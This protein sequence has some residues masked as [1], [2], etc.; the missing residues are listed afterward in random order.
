MPN[1]SSGT[2]KDRS[3]TTLQVI[4]N[5]SSFNNKTGALTV[6]GG[7]GILE[8]IN[9]GGNAVIDGT[10]QIPGT[11]ETGSIIIGTSAIENYVLT[12]LNS[13]GNTQ[14]KPNWISN[15]TN[16]LH[17]LNN[18][19]I[20]TTQSHD[21]FTLYGN[22][23]LDGTLNVPDFFNVNGNISFTNYL[24]DASATYVLPGI[25]DTIVGTGATQTLSNKTLVSP[26][27]SGNM[28]FNA[29]G[30]IINL[31]YPS[32]SSDAATKGYVDDLINGLDWQDSVL[33]FSIST[34]PGSP[35][36]GDRYIVPSLPSGAW[37][38]QENKITFWNGTIWEF[39]V[40]N[41]GFAVLI[42]DED[43]QY[44]YNGTSWVLFGSLVNH[45]SLIGLSNDEHIQY[46]LLAGRAGGQELYGGISGGDNLIIDS[47]TSTNKGDILLQPKGG[48]VGIGVTDSLY[49]LHILEENSTLQQLVVEQNN[50]SGQAGLRIHHKNDIGTGYNI[51]QIQNGQV[52]IIQTSASGH[53]YYY[54][55]GASSDYRFFN[56][57]SDLERFG[58]LSDGTVSIHNN[59]QFVNN[60]TILFNELV[61]N[62]NDQDLIYIGPTGNFGIGVSAQNQF[63][64]SQSA[65]IGDTL[66]IGTTGFGLTSDINH[67]T[68][69]S[70]NRV[71]FTTN[72]EQRMIIGSTGYIGIGVTQPQ[73]ILDVGG[74]IR[75]NG[76]IN[77]NTEI[78]T[79]PQT[80]NILVG[81]SS[82][83]TLTNKSLHDTSVYFVNQNDNTKVLDFSLSSATSGRT[84][85]IVSNH[86][87]NR[88]IF[89][90]DASDILVGKNTVDVLTNKTLTSPVIASIVN[91]GTLTLPISTDTLVGRNTVDTLTNKT[92][93]SPVI[94]GN[95]TMADTTYMS[96]DQVRARDVDGLLLTDDGNNG[97]FIQDGGNV[98]IG[99]STPTSTLDVF[100]DA[101]F[102]NNTLFVQQSTNSVGIGTNTPSTQ[103]H[104]NGSGYFENNLTVNGNLNVQG[105]LT[106]INT[107]NLNINDPLLK[108]ADGNSG[109]T[110]DIGFFG[111]F[112][113]GGVTKYTGLFRDT[114]AVN[115]T[116]R[117]FT[118]LETEPLNTIN[119]LG[120][121]YDNANLS[122]GDLEAEFITIGTLDTTYPLLINKTVTNNWSQR[123]NNNETTIYIGHS[124]G[125]GMSIHTGTVANNTYI[126][127]F[128]NNTTN[129]IFRVQ[130]NGLVGIQSTSPTEK[131][132]I[133]GINP[134]DGAKIGNAKIGVWEGNASY[135]AYTHDTVHG[136]TSSYAIKQLNT[137]ETYLNTAATKS[138]H[139]HVGD[140][141]QMIID[142]SGNVGI[143]TLSPQKKLHV[144][145]G[146]LVTSDLDVYG[147]LNIL[148]QISA[149][150]AESIVVQ[151]P[152]LKIANGNTMD[153]IDTGFYIQYGI[154]G[155]I[156]QG[157][158]Y[159][160]IIRDNDDQLFK[161]FHQ[162][163]IEPGTTQV[164]TD[165]ASFQYA[166]LHLGGA[167]IHDN[168]IIGAT[169][170]VGIGSN[171][172][173]SSLDVIGNGQFTGNV[174]ANQFI[175]LSDMTSKTNIRSLSPQQCIETIRK[176]NL[177][178][179]DYKDTNT[180]S[181]GV[182]AQQIEEMF[183]LA[184]TNQNGTKYVNYQMLF[185]LMMGCIKSLLPN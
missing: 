146:T 145:G 151:D 89:L 90:P 63:E 50:I 86:S 15:N 134:G 128:G 46:A 58:I 52:N 179:F 167:K 135:T 23:F 69:F 103:L 94:T 106:T 76:T 107:T 74:N 157:I 174:T 185:I 55:K 162:L 35:S 73:D 41:E 183:P 42:E 177:F 184:V 71:E 93:S 62:S 48:H 82:I 59:L 83:D 66:Y 39:I 57:N 27:V 32:L 56:T 138:L 160:G 163:A 136:I 129:D 182:M 9:V 75:I 98:G 132:D 44:N 123:I 54:N 144:E 1:A 68:L 153:L 102:N 125:L 137:G 31:N 104:V 158:R 38:G 61:F 169:G 37:V 45:S 34:P 97:I 36:P 166:S 67:M 79:L 78:F 150:N 95:M 5:T 154:S 13:N 131:L 175:T 133:Y 101:K 112:I 120:T 152:I 141:P 43:K 127:R 119:I 16:D 155:G 22:M 40:P 14:W 88:Q 115:K 33:S 121:G 84:M 47:T 7:V 99:I 143:G 85:T 109:D 139:F 113:D 6:R 26:Y 108:F 181:I 105:T 116:F 170:R 28:D 3:L 92:I 159:A 60:A 124:D 147:D 164:N 30:K 126:V 4:G 172:P 96:T 64:I 173:V 140:I 142:S 53:V 10:L 20:G 178:E 110:V 149:I 8:N 87:D 171:T 12:A 168:L 11:I 148:G 21:L 118:N 114:S 156:T 29:S 19:S 91:I 165:D 77:R 161:I 70:T 81:V 117:L 65:H 49:S 18:I 2:Y 111:M 24:R 25:T 51:R 176:I 122:L 100:G 72:D 80:S 130:N 17:Y 180:H